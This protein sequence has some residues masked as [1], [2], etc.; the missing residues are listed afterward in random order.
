M[1]DRLQIPSIALSVSALLAACGETPSEPS[2]DPASEAADVAFASSASANGAGGAV[3][4]RFST[5]QFILIFDAERQLLSAHM[6][7]NL[8]APEGEFNIVEVQRV[9]TPSQIN[10]VASQITDRDS[11]A[12]VYRVTSP[13]DAS[14]SGA[15]AFLGFGDIVDV[16]EFCAFLTGPALI[17]EGTV[18]SI[19]TFSAASFH[20][21][22]TGRVQGVD[23]QVY[24]LTE[25]YHL[26]ADAHDPN[27]PDTF[28]EIISSVQLKP[29]G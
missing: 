7:S 17:A 8:C 9:Q 16:A 15:L 23:G 10:E 18:Q 11:K 1:R 24:H 14:L 26:N 4:G 27:N 21:R 2:P 22:R 29:V 6:P 12:A 19:S 20:L 5:V 28:R 13:S 25:I 3:I